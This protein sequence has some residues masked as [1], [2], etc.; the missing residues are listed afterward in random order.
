MNETLGKMIDI[1]QA[2]AVEI[3]K[4]YRRPFDVDFKG[5]SDPVTE[6]DRIANHLICSRLER[7]FPDIPVIAEE[8]PP[9]TWGRNLSA[10]KVFFVDPVDGTKEFV[11]RN[12]QFVVMIGLLE[13][14]APTHGVLYS[15]VTQT[16][17]AG[18]VGQGAIRREASGAERVLK[19]L[20]DVSLSESRVVSS[21]SNRQ[22][23]L[24]AQALER[25]SPAQIVPIGSA[26]LKGAAVA[27]GS[28]DI[29]LAPGF[30]GCLWD[31]CAPEALIR[32]VGGVYTDA[33]GVPLDYRA[34]TVENHRG[35]VA[36]SP[37]VHSE[38][39]ARISDLLR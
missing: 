19:P 7:S 6:A 33:H 4:V 17:W 30:A 38:V 10:E 8:S 16:L 13:G 39:I 18:V 36:A 32:S 20:S 35:A 29:Y 22:S 31:S 24:N 27:D 14:D 34:T 1:A 9:E 5:P 23:E 26:G 37:L 25:V 12:D 21:R 2:A 3:M 15:P 28:A 11:A